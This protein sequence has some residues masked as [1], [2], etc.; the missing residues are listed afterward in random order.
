[1]LRGENRDVITVTVFSLSFLVS[2]WAML[3][4]HQAQLFLLA[5]CSYSHPLL[6]FNLLV[7]V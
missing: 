3:T 1:M 5:F 4:R 7:I 6:L 2:E